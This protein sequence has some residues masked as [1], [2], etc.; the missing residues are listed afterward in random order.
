[1][2]TS[3]LIVLIGACI[4][5]KG[6]FK[7]DRRYGIGFRFNGLFVLIGLVV[8]IVGLISMKF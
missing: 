1:M 7:R 6:W 4:F 8:I 5:A 2:E 3:Q